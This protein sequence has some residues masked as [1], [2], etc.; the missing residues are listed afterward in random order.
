MPAES[1]SKQVKNVSDDSAAVCSGC[2]GTGVK[3]VPGKGAKICDECQQPK[4][5]RL[6]TAAHIPTH[7]R[8]CDFSNYEPIGTSQHWAAEGC[9]QFVD[10][11][12]AVDRGLLLM[13]PVGV[14]KT[15]L[16]VSI[17]RGL[18]KKGVPCRFSEFGSL[19]KKIQDSYNPISGTS[20][21]RV[22]APIYQAEVLVLDELGA[23]VPT[24]WVRD[25]MYQII[26]TRYN[27]NR[28]TVFT[29]NFMDDRPDFRRS[30]DESYSDQ[31]RSLSSKSD[32]KVPPSI[33]YTLDERIGI[34]LRSRLYQ[35][36]TLFVIKGEDFR[37]KESRRISDDS[38]RT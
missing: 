9:K 22:L 8:N 4:S 13:G 21:M 35:M 20:E 3:I 37:K 23:S 36:C 27:E 7:F 28:V 14:G 38:N 17:I 19:L 6:L 29:T 16:A 12:P 5:D 10:N 33:A 30:E 34:P 2:F 32:K 18:L 31:K 25:T 24:D 26:N 11:Y 1:S 15:H